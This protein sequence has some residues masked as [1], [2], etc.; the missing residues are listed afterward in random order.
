MRQAIKINVSIQ[1]RAATSN[2]MTGVALAASATSASTGKGASFDNIVAVFPRIKLKKELFVMTY[3]QEIIYK[4]FV[5]SALLA[6]IAVKQEQI[7]KRL[8]SDD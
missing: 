4:L 5:S 3:L 8:C 7:H 1:H 6:W 2:T